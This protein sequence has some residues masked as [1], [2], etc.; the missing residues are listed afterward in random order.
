MERLSFWLSC[1]LC[2]EDGSYLKTFSVGYSPMDLNPTGHKNQ[3]ILRYHLKAV[4]KMG[5]SRINMRSFLN[6]INYYR[7]I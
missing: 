2:P 6:N 7:L 5:A 1:L 4:P 3:V